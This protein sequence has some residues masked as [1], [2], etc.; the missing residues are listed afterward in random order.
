[1]RDEAGKTP[2]D[3][4]REVAS[5]LQS[6]CDWVGV[7]AGEVAPPR[8]Q[9]ESGEVCRVPEMISVDV[10]TL[11]PVFCQTFQL[12]MIPSVK[13]ASLGLVKKM[14]HYPDP[15]TL[16][17][18]STKEFGHQLVAVLATVLDTEEDEEGQLVTLSVIQDLMGKAGAGESR[19]LEHFGKVTLP[20]L[21]CTARCTCSMSLRKGNP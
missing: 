16:E 9:Q 5:L 21:A 14:L 3:K 2:L 7:G 8:T 11:L 6:T 12:T 15:V 10:H 17:E 20:S 1:M 13:R 4:V 18:V 19:W